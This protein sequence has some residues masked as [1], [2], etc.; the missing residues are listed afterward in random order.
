MIR[1]RFYLITFIVLTGLSIYLATDLLGHQSMARLNGQAQAESL[2]LGVTIGLLAILVG[3]V[4][5]LWL[6]RALEST[7]IENRF[8]QGSLKQIPPAD[9]TFQMVAMDEISVLAEEGEDLRWW[10]DECI[11]ER[12]WEAGT[13]LHEM[14][15]RIGR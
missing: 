1:R 13:N 12:V 15:E 8:S 2:L 6:Q 4:C 7:R 14:F 11:E 3:L 9:S 10:K 5:R